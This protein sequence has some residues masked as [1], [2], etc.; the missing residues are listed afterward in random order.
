MKIPVTPENYRK[1]ARVKRGRDWEWG[2]QD[3]HGGGTGTGTLVS[4]SISTGFWADVQWE[5]SKVIWNYRVGHAGYYD[6]YYLDEPP[7]L[8]ELT[9]ALDKLE[10]KLQKS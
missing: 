5:G 7:S 9:E 4:E 8:D 1:G 3:I 6:L 10:E 2:D